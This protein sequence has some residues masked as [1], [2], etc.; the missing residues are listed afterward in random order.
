MT[1]Q[2]AHPADALDPVRGELLRAARADADA[3]LAEARQQAATVVDTARDQA[4]D[5]VEEAR[6]RGEEDGAAAGEAALVQAR[7]AARA[8]ELAAR[9]EA[10]AELHRRVADAV[11]GL[12]RSPG[13]PA[14]RTALEERARRLLGPGAT[15]EEHPAGGVIGRTPG[16]LVDLGLDALALRAVDRLGPRAET[17]W[18]PAP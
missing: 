9:G 18:G 2:A 13:Y 10:W 15:V 5:V 14:L 7:R 17:L 16:R 4:R 6:R 8:Q 11:R 1:G 3:L 12:R